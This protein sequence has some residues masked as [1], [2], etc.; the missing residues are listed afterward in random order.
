VTETAL[1]FARGVQARRAGRADEA[2]ALFERVL[3][4]DPRH[5]DAAVALAFLL[6][7]EGEGAR[8]ADALRPLVAATTTSASDLAAIAAFASELGALDL[9]REAFARTRADTNPA[10]LLAHGRFLLQTGRFEEARATFREAFARD[11]EAAAAYYQWAQTRRW[12][13]DE[14][15]EALALLDARAAAPARVETRACLA[16]ARAKIADDLGRP[17][18]ALRSLHEANALRR[19][20]LAPFDHLYYEEW[21]RLFA[22][23][24]VGRGAARAPKPESASAR[25]PPSPLFVV[26][27]PRSGTTLLARLLVHRFG[28]ES[29][30]ETDLV[31]RLASAIAGAGARAEGLERALR[32][33]A[34]EERD[35]LAR[36]FL[37][38]LRGRVTNGAARRIVDKNPLNFWYVPL[39]RALF[40]EAPVLWCRRDPR[41][42]VL[43]LYFQNF[44]HPALDFSYDLR[45]LVRY[46]TNAEA[47]ARAWLSRGDPALHAV[48]YEELV[49]APERVLAALAETALAESYGSTEE[50]RDQSC[51]EERLA[52]AS[53]WQARQ[54]L[55]TR[56][57]GRWKIYA[58]GLL[59][60]EPALAT[61]GFAEGREAEGAPLG[62]S[63]R[64]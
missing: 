62:E 7:D 11:P 58:S 29:A 1:L 43:S 27:L 55:H 50:T 60:A 23:A 3:E 36:S 53:A 47:F 34:P 12:E 13:D 5:R 46:V 24:A 18:E 4:A 20:T 14:G 57:I 56:S 15:E 10:V 42:V 17:E 33:L 28:V 6:R 54:P 64:E 39:L 9:A 52:T 61:L 38:A 35:A 8:A 25:E 51:G 2:R 37:R 21:S 22:P 32:A 16:F 59:A 19:S 44:A 30:G 40:P 49:R 31:G 45:D 41:D 48:A 63:A 26:G